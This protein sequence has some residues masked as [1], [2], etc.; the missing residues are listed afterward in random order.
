MFR[1]G[2]ETKKFLTVL[3][4]FRSDEGHDITFNRIIVE[5]LYLFSIMSIEQL[6]KGGAEHC[7]VRRKPRAVSTF[8]KKTYEL[9][10]V[11]SL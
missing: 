11:R 4:D 9:L 8:L 6:V 2:K 3:G 10:N 1:S 5:F 7:Q